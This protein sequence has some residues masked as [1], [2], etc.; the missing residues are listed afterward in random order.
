M[1]ETLGHGF[2]RHPPPP[3]PPSGPQMS[4]ASDSAGWPRATALPPCSPP[5]PALLRPRF[6]LSPNGQVSVLTPRG[7]RGIWAAMTADS[8]MRNS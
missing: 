5:S 3:P 4:P 2:P 1:V 6:P 7:R 8:H